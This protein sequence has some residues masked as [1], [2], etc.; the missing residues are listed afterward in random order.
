M[1]EQKNGN[2]KV[3][4]VASKAKTTKPKSASKTSERKAEERVVSRPQ[5]FGD[6]ILDEIVL[7]GII[8]FCLLVI[9]CIVSG[10]MGILGEILGGFFKGLLG[11]GGI[12]LPI[13]VI[14]YCVWVLISKEKNGLFLRAYGGLL[15]IITIAA[16][17][18]VL[19]PMVL[20]VQIQFVQRCVMYFEDGSFANGG[21]L[22]GLLG[23][24]L[25]QAFGKAGSILILFAVL[26]VSMIMTTGKSFFYGVY[27]LFLYGKKQKKR[28][29]EK[30]K[31]KADVIR[32]K[33]EIQEQK[34]E[35]KRK[36]KEA[37]EF[38]K[39]EK[40]NYNILLSREE[41][42][43]E[44]ME[45]KIVE[46]VVFKPS[47]KKTLYVKRRNPIYD[48][49]QDMAELQERGA[50]AEAA[51]EKQG[52][53]AASDTPSV[54]ERE[55]VIQSSHGF[56]E[57]AEGIEDGQFAWEE[58]EQQ[59]EGQQE[60]TQEISSSSP[61]DFEESKE[62]K[63]EK[64]ETE[65]AVQQ[66]DKEAEAGAE[67]KE[68]PYV[69]PPLDLLGKNTS[70]I[71]KGSKVE[72]VRNAQK[73]E[74]TLKSFGVIAKV[75]QINQGPTVTRYELAPNQGV[76]V[77]KIVNLADDIALNLAAQGIR[78]E[79]PIPGKAAVGIEV[80]NE[81]TQSV[82]LRNVLESEAFQNFPSN[83]A[84]AL[85]EDIAGQPIVTDIAKMPHLLIAGATGSGKS[86]CIN[87]LI[88]S[89]L[90]K[91]DPKEVK[92]LLVDPKVVELSVYNG[93]PHLLIPVVTDPKKASAALNWAVREMLSRYNDFAAHNVR[94]IKGFN[95]MKKSKGE[96]DD[97]MPQIVIIIDELADLMMAAPGEVEDAICRLA[98]MARAAGMH[99][100]I[101]TQRPSVDVI[102]GVIKANIP[103]RLAFAVSSGT[104][105]RTILNMVG[106]EK[107][108]GKGDMLFHP[109]GMSKPV[110][111]Q[112]AFVTDK[113]VESIVNF[114]KR[115]GHGE[116]DTS[117]IE[118]I[119]AT[120]HTEEEDTEK[121]EFF[122][123]AVDLVVEKEK[124]SV[125]MLQRQ[126]RIGYNRAARLMDELERCHIVGQ[127]D[128]SKPRRVL[129]TKAQLY[130]MRK[131]DLV[132]EEE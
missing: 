26:I 3:Q 116:Y 47:E 42:K 115:D 125:S 129:L 39:L 31:N 110:R 64:E 25:I 52:E 78:I 99:L 12:L 70:F 24:M 80:P 95:E 127:E 73:L 79:A 131:P 29:H 10:R 94:D 132:D 100:I 118:K 49:V 104:D 103:S 123:Q 44:D 68:A 98:Q 13:G 120:V 113:E 60:G 106:A 5:S 46:A 69:F 50:M 76:K 74:E 119:T 2:R 82:F 126:F 77:S 20:S 32:K 22:G 55:I 59:E 97:L 130:D 1:A 51:M 71:S 102:T 114:V 15:F 121:D 27:H 72:M 14:L 30:I 38:E 93:I 18:Y 56:R 89:I 57:D 111:I 75:I 43:S 40:G 87:T 4:K 6:S 128:G 62:Q 101:A 28:H 92:L 41:P 61:D 21:L 107:L 96:T 86:V 34:I 67:M 54:E 33:E 90:Y 122:D 19:H 16:W 81:E 91:A 53:S 35:Q 48:Y 66:E 105:S 36:R 17:A 23:N 8:A 117:M 37:K 63:N 85:G 83:L 84:F 58:K 65:E 109:A 108:M 88:T 124:A 45:E 7:I 9:F 11:I 112:G